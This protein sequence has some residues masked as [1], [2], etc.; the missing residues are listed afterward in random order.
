MRRVSRIVRDARRRQAKEPDRSDQRAGAGA[1]GKPKRGRSPVLCGIR[2]HGTFAL[3]FVLYRGFGP[4]SHPN[5]TSLH[6]AM[7]MREL[8]APD[9]RC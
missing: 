5:P 3:L 4:D 1:G 8:R 2:F 6:S 9:L 7:H